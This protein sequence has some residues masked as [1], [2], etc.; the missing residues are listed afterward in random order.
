MKNGLLNNVSLG[1]ASYAI[2]NYDSGKI[3]VDGGTLKT[4][5]AS[6]I[7]M[8]YN[9]G[10]EVTV[11]GGMIDAG[12][13]GIQIQAGT[14]AAITV[15]NGTISGKT[16]ALYVYGT[17]YSSQTD[18]INVAIH[19]GTFNGTV[20]TY[21]DFTVD[22]GIFNDAFVVSSYVLKPKMLTGGTFNGA[23]WVD[24]GYFGMIKD[25][26]LCDYT[27][28][29]DANGNIISRTPTTAKY[30]APFDAVA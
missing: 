17:N 6:G 18:D 16:Y 8:F 1:S 9:N 24:S 13:T 19:G 7:R 26:I 4:A 27:K 12:W 22:G 23:A 11:N 3:T 25:G 28:E 15:N 14:K 30:S 21:E 2:D 10:G 20:K 29:T 5:A